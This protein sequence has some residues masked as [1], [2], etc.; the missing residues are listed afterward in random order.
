METQAAFEC[1]VYVEV[2][3]IVKLRLTLR[4]LIRTISPGYT[5][6]YL[7]YSMITQ[8]VNFNLF[9]TSAEIGS[10]TKAPSQYYNS[11]TEL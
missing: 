3:F 1:D 4:M 11:I 6:S 2:R 10:S 8:E 9:L 5:Q 7:K